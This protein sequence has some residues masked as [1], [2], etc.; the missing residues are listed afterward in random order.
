MNLGLSDKVALVIADTK[1]I[2]AAVAVS[3]ARRSAHTTGVALQIDGG[4]VRST[5]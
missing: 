4:A 2:A 1:G 3:V 5:L